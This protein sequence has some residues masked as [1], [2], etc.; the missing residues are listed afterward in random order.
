MTTRRLCILGAG[1]MGRALI[2]GLLR[3]GTRAEAH[4]RRARTL[5][6][7]R[8]TLARELGISAS[9]DNEAAVARCRASSCWP[10]SRRTRRRCCNRWRQRLA[11][12]RPLLISVCAGTRVA[13]LRGLGRCGRAGGARHAEP[14]GTGRCR[15]HGPVRAAAR[16]RRRSARRGGDPQ[17]RGRGGVGA[18]RG[19]ARCGDGALGQRTGVFLPAGRVHG[20]R[21]ATQLGL[22]HATA[23]RLAVA[24]LLRLGPAGARRRMPTSRGC[25]PR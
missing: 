12:A 14:P 22:E 13:T 7:A 19:R 8:A 15:H 3:A 1:N 23:Q 6:A 10:S 18:D 16:C 4:Q 17:A 24:T 5:P 2:S 25:A 21:P 11:G 20:A 9:A